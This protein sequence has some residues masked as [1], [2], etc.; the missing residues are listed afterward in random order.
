M[1]GTERQGFEFILYS[2]GELHFCMHHKAVVLFGIAGVILTLILGAFSIVSW[3]F[4]PI[5]VTVFI[6][7]SS[8]ILTYERLRTDATKPKEA[9]KHDEDISELWKPLP[10]INFTI[11]QRL[12]SRTC[13]LPQVGWE[14]YND[15]PYQLRVRIEV[16]PILGGQ[17]L[18]PL[19]DNDIN[20]TNPY[21]AEP[22][23]YVFANGCFT[24][25]QICAVSK[26]ELILEIRTIVEDINDPKKGEHKL[27]PRRWKY[28]REHGIW[29]YYPQRPMTQ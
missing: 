22:N 6:G 11:A 16:H 13:Y 4:V 10:K 14:A 27:V 25:P 23:S 24:L 8:L 2:L 21:E 26:D 3:Q 19:S 1:L 7:L 17:D 18:H 20:G 12:P 9:K 15:S 28:V 29:S 5:F